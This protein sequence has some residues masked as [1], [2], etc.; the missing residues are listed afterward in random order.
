MSIQVEMAVTE[1]LRRV[2]DPEM[3]LNIVDL[4]L[5]RRIDYEE[6]T[7]DVTIGLTLTSPMCPMAPEIM[8]AVRNKTLSVPGVKHCQV[9]MVWSP[10][11]NPRTDASE[12]VRA[13]LGIW[14]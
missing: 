14:D 2:I 6:E 10:P 12:D 1:V 8:N 5:V 9:E 7:G 13:E 3:N 4:G 11:W